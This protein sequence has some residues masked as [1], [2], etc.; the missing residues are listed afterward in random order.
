MSLIASIYLVVEELYWCVQKDSFISVFLEELST[1]LIHDAE[2]THMESKSIPTTH[3][4]LMTKFTLTK[5]QYKA[6]ILWGFEDCHV[7]FLIQLSS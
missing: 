1:S 6:E 7:S 2:D 5:L 4:N 3:G